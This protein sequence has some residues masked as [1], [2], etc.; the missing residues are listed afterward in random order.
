M[1]KVTYAKALEYFQ[2][3]DLYWE[4][5]CKGIV[6]KREE[7]IAD[8]KRN[9]NTPNCND[10]S[11]FEVNGAIVAMDDLIYDFKLPVQTGEE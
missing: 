8:M 10:S 4:A 3:N 7:Y 1:E 9:M 11:R 5:F 6:A 2:S